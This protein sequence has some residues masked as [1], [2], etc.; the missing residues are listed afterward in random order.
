MFLDRLI[1]A[2]VSHHVDYA[3]VGGYAVAL[4]GAIRGTLDIDAVIGLTESQFLQAE[5]AL[6]EL[7][8]EPRLPVR[9]ERVFQFRKEYI[10]ERN[11]IAW[12]FY[13]PQ[14]PIESV[15]IILT[16][17]QHQMKTVAIQGSGVIYQVAAIPDLI[18]MK[19]ESG[20]PQDLADIKAL[21]K[22]LK[23]RQAKGTE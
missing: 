5:R 17:D 8:L 19:T 9:A 6:L 12:N 14:N 23:D 18:Q 15:D 13:N 3:L 20:R 21:N 4:H 11:L 2:F 16:H 10:Q 7:G 1:A 22:I